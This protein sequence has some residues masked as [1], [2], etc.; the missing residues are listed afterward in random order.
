M[1]PTDL[2]G[3][4]F[5]K[6]TVTGPPVR[7]Q[8]SDGRGVGWKCP[9]MCTCGSKEMAWHFHLTRGRHTSCQN[10]SQPKATFR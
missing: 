5:G 2:T 1:K 6:L 3:K 4:K 7:P 8:N 10:C 9:V